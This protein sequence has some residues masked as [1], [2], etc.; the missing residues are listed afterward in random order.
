M[1]NF[2]HLLTYLQSNSWNELDL[3]R[4]EVRVF[5]PHHHVF[6]VVLNV[7]FVKTVFKLSYKVM[8]T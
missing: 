3:K 1:Q 4:T 6:T 7:C 8:G 2:S 5:C